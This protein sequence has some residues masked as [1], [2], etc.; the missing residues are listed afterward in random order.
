MFLSVFLC[1]HPWLEILLG[2]QA[3]IDL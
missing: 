2:M 1:V 3:S